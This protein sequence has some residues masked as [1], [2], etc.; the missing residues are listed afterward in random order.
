MPAARLLPGLLLGLLL[1]AGCSPNRLVVRGAMPLMAGGIEAMNRETDLDFARAALPANLKMLEG[2]LASDPDNRR[3]LLY[4]AQ[5]FY[6]YSFAFLEQDAPRR[7]RAMYQRCFDY[8]RRALALSGLGPDP[9]RVPMDGLRR[10]LAGLGRGAVPALF[11]TA[12]CWAKVIDLSRTE[13]ARIADL[14]RTAALMRRV[15]QLDEG[16]YHAGPHLFFAVY[17][18]S[19]SRLLGGDPERARRH[20]DRARELTG[21]RL[22]LVDVLEARYLDRQILDRARFHR[23]LTGVLA[24]SVPRD[25]LAFANRLAQRDARRLLAREAAWF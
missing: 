5:G 25:G 15:L 22:L 3:L 12:S 16:F 11:W 6:G 23:L 4:A 1:V 21:H 20:F 9:R 8:G 10:A 19:R 2:M 24:R 7:A 18:G 14:G 13:P 17:Y